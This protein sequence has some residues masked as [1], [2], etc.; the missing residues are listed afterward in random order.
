MIGTTSPT[1]KPP[2]TSPTTKPPT[3]SPTTG[4]VSNLSFE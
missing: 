1:T 3:T 2:T 4:K